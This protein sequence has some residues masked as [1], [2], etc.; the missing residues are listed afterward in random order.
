MSGFLLVVFLIIAV[1]K[2]VADQRGAIYQGI[3]GEESPTIPTISTIPGSHLECALAGVPNAFCHSEVR[4]SQRQTLSYCVLR[5]L[6]FPGT[7]C[8]STVT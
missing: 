4:K 6:W 7:T 8:M 3:D 5:D 2:Y 1:I